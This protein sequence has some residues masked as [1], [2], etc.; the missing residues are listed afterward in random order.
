MLHAA[1]GRFVIR[2]N[3]WPALKDSVIR[4]SGADPALHRPVARSGLAD[5]GSSAGADTV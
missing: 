4:H 3:F 2:A 1:S 5:G